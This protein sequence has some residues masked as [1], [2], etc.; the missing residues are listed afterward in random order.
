MLMQAIASN[1][2]TYGM[3]RTHYAYCGKVFT[4]NFRSDDW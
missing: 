3:N 2:V 4:F 1:D